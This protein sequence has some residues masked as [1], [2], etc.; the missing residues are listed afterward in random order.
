M[1]ARQCLLRLAHSCLPHDQRTVVWDGQ[2]DTSW[3]M[4]DRTA[5]AR[6]QQLELELTTQL[7]SW[8]RE[9]EPLR[10]EL[11]QQQLKIDTAENAEGAKSLEQVGA[12]WL[13]AII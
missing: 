10:R 5:I 2:L 11:S 4:P 9:L 13:Q 8:H 3:Q 6:H 1:H 12:L 7:A